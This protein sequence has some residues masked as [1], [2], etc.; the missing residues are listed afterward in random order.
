[1]PAPKTAQPDHTTPATIDD[2]IS[3]ACAH[4]SARIRHAASVVVR[5]LILVMQQH[6]A[7]RVGLKPNDTGTSIP[8]RN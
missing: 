6:S 3:F 4:G 2:A 1:M 8:G 5:D 7:I